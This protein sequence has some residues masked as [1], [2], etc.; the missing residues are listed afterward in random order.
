MT[1]ERVGGLDAEQVVSVSVMLPWESE[2]VCAQARVTAVDESGVVALELDGA[3]R[4]DPPPPDGL[5]D[6][7]AAPP[8]RHRP[9]P[10][11]GTQR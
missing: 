3:E 8:P 2:E 11:G 9:L 10:P 5:R 4:D 6:R 7:A 1:L